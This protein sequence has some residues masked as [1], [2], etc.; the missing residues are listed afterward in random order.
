MPACFITETIEDLHLLYGEFYFGSYLSKQ[1]QLYTKLKPNF[2]N[3]LKN[4]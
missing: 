1:N 3:F 4:N 2:I